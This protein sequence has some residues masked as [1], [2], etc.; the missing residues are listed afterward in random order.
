MTDDQRRIFS[1]VWSYWTKLDLPQPDRATVIAAV[2]STP[3]DL[4]DYDRMKY[5]IRALG[6]AE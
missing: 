6:W 2:Q 1:L 3:A 5:A 4:R